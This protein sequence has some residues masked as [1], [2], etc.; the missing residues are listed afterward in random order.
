MERKTIMKVVKKILSGETHTTRI[1]G[2]YYE[3]KYDDEFDVV[4]VEGRHTNSRAISTM[5]PGDYAYTHGGSIFVEAQNLCWQI[6]EELRK[7]LSAKKEYKL[8]DGT[9]FFDCEEQVLPPEAEINDD[10]QYD[11]KYRIVFEAENNGIDNSS[12]NVYEHVSQFIAYEKISAFKFVA[13]YR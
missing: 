12:E 11:F 6:E 1:Q 2:Y 7:F 3:I 13:N 5:N 4:T 8:I 9:F 10:K